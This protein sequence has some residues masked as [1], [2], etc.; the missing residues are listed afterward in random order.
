MWK[1][2]KGKNKCDTG[3]EYIIIILYSQE[4]ETILSSRPVWKILSQS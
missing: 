4:I 3:L 1:N 2:E